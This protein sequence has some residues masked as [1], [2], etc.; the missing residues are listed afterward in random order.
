[1]EAVE[2]MIS[3]NKELGK[4]GIQAFMVV[5]WGQLVSLIGSAITAFALNLWVYERTKSVTLFSLSLTAM[6]LPGLLISPVAGA[7]VDRHSRKAAMILSDCGAGLC[8]M[9]IA[10][11]VFR[12]V[13]H[14]W[15]IYCLA[16]LASCFSSLRWL[17]YSALTTSL[18]PKDRYGKAAGLIQIAEALSQILAPMAAIALMGKARLQGILV[19]DIV[20]FLFSIAT[21]LTVSDAGALPEKRNTFLWEEIKEGWLYLKAHRELAR[22]LY[23]FAFMNLIVGYFIVLSVP[24]LLTF[25]TESAIG[26][27]LTIAI[28]GMMLGGVF[29][30]ATGGTKVKMNAIL[31]AVWFAGASIIACSFARGPVWYTIGAFAVYFCVPVV[32]AASQ[33]IWQAKVAPEKQGRVFATR[34]IVAMASLPFAYATAGPLSNALGRWGNYSVAQGIDNMFLLLGTLTLFAGIFCAANIRFRCMESMLPDA[35]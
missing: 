9:T 15:H 25:T 26:T 3:E 4:P 32:N 8:S 10:V 1:M 28:S 20:T 6:V 22:L 11:L 5:W 24:L 16:A 33:A 27:I 23:F 17:A 34:R 21:L 12:G 14:V 19:L 30:A 2:E 18:A 35:A 7:L 31:G 13:L 29:M